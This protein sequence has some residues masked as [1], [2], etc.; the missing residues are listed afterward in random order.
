MNKSSSNLVQKQNN[1]IN[2]YKLWI[3]QAKFDLEASKKSI[4][5]GFNEW[6]CYQA[7]QSVEK[8]LKSVIIH[9][10]WRA[11]QTHK[12]GVLLSICNKINK[13]FINVKFNYRKIEGY[14]FISRYPFV[15]P[16]ANL[17]PHD[18]VSK[19]DAQ[20][21][22]DVAQNIIKKITNFLENSNPIKGEELDLEKFYYTNKEI[23]T[24]IQNV[25]SILSDDTV[26]K[27]KK[28]TLFGSFAR[29]INPPKT[30]T[31]DLLIV[32]D[33]QFPFI[34]R[35]EYLRNITK[36]GEPII[37]PLIYTPEEFEL[38]FNQEGEGYIESAVEEG[39]VLFDNKGANT[40]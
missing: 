3:S 33:T 19:E 10:G 31:M 17:T 27:V 38:M 2:R 32:A 12:L 24:R 26:L 7:V 36:G 28:I 21:C 16:N 14:T 35:M 40:F 13:S 5:F 1:N 34:D 20:A 15:L 29:E 8:A 11:P 9:A 18:L 25:V 6:T 23:Q 37:E 39:K 22:I 30:S 4:E